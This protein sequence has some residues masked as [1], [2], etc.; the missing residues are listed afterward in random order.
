MHRKGR[1]ALK[2]RYVLK[3]EFAK[4]GI[5]LVYNDRTKTFYLKIKGAPLFV[6]GEDPAL[7]G[8]HMTGYYAYR[9]SIK[10][11]QDVPALAQRAKELYAEQY[12]DN[13]QMLK[14]LNPAA[15]SDYESLFV[16]DEELCVQDE[17]HECIDGYLWATDGLVSRLQDVLRSSVSSDVLSSLE[18]IN[19]FPV[20]NLQEG[21]MELIGTF[22]YY[23]E[24]AGTINEKRGNVQLPLNDADVAALETAMEQYCEK[25]YHMSC[26]AFLNEAREHVGLPVLQPSTLPSPEKPPLDARILEAQM[27]GLTP[28]SE[29]DRPAPT[30]ERQETPF[31]KEAAL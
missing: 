20:F 29:K 16:F 22:W 10:D 1:F 6:E 7:A 13:P 15:T 23:E 28:I 27:K 30:P 17:K 21:S 24:E 19:F 9:G 25:T 12:A 11:I 18:N 2:N 8:A 26:L 5:D 14:Y 3:D 31:C 4:H